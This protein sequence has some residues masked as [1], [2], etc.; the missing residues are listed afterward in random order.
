MLFK[1]LHRRHLQCN[2]RFKVSRYDIGDG[3]F[4]GEERTNYPI[5]LP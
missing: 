5:P 3:T 1:K 2:T 4:V